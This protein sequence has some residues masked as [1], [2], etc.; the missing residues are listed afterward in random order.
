MNLFPIM[1]AVVFVVGACLG[2]LA[3]WA[4]YTWAWN[5]RPLSPWSRLA[6]GASPRGRLARLP[7]V[8]WFALR[9]EAEVHG[10]R[11]W[12]RPLLIEIGMGVGLA[13]LY[14]WEVARLGLIQGQ[15]G[16]SLAVRA[17]AFV[18]VTGPSG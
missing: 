2:A 18:A 15:A 6:P 9:H 12:V 3:N 4:I 8:G 13:A 1:L 10:A 11:F 17:G 7:V 16:V 5:S 14:W